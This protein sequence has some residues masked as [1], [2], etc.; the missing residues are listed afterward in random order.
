MSVTAEHPAERTRGRLRRWVPPAT[1]FALPMGLAVLVVVGTFGA[2]R[3]VTEQGTLTGAGLALAVAGALTLGWRDRGP[4][5]VAAITVAFSL[6]YLALDQ[7]H[8]PHVIAPTLGLFHGMLRGE[9][10]A[11]LT[12]AAIGFA[13]LWLVLPLRTDPGP[14]DVVHVAAVAGW[15][16]VTLAVG[17]L[18]RQRDERL[19]EQKRTREAEHRRVGTEERL[20]IAQDLHDVLAHNLSLINVQSGVA[21][22][23]VEQRPE[24]AGIALAAI[25]EA[26]AEALAEVRHVLAAL[27]AEAPAPR[28]PTVRIDDLRQLVE[29]AATSHLDVQ[30]TIEGEA[31][32]PASVEHAA[33][34]IVQESLTNVTRHAQ[35]HEVRV[36]VRRG[37]DGVSVHV[38][39]DGRNG[40]AQVPRPTQQRQSQDLPAETSG[41]GLDG[42]RARAEAL[43]GWLRAGPR[44]TGGFA[45]RAWLPFTTAAP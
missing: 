28:G 4:I 6:L 39:D 31:P 40:A 9:R 20:R 17:E 5:A 13:V 22:H 35:A 16:G 33:Y 32:V 45:V 44:E 41:S 30:L 8:G 3:S 23:I 25:K 38:E 18:W 36:V 2:A 1:H 29:R 7:P 21:L 10:R 43:G 11:T 24:Q 19:R 42:M 26:S 27:R 37:E 12:I 14:V 15:L 34:R